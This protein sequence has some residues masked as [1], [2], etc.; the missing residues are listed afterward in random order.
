M[1]FTPAKLFTFVVVVLFGGGLLQVYAHPQPALQNIPLQPKQPVLVSNQPPLPIFG[2]GSDG[3]LVVSNGQTVYTDEIRA[4]LLN[5]VQA[6]EDTICVSITSTF[7]VGDEIL[8]IQIFGDGAGNYEFKHIT[9][10]IDSCWMR[11][12]SGLQQTYTTPN[13]RA[14][15]VRVPNYENV[16]VESGG[17]LTAHEWDGSTGGIVSF[18]C[19]N[20]CEINGLVN[21]SGKGFKGG[22]GN[23]VLINPCRTSNG[24]QGLSFT[25]SAGCTRSANGGGGGAGSGSFGS[26]G[27]GGYGSSG[28]NGGGDGWGAGGEQYGVTDLSKIY[29]GSGGGGGNW[30]TNPYGGGRLSIQGND[31]S[32]QAGGIAYISARNITALNISANGNPGGNSNG[33]FGGHAGGGG[34]GG[35]IKIIGQS[36]VLGS[37]QS[38]GGAGGDGTF[39]DGG[40]GGNGR[41]NIEY[42]DAFSGTTNPPA[43][44][45]SGNCALL[46]LGVVSFDN[47]LSGWSKD[48]L[49]SFRVGTAINPDV[50]VVLLVDRLGKY[51][52]EIVEVSN[53]VVETSQVIPWLEPQ[54]VFELDTAS[55]NNIATFLQWGRETYPAGRTMVTFIGHGTGPSPAL[56]MPGRA[57]VPPL[58]RPYRQR[59]IDVTNGQY[60]STTEL[61]E[62]LNLATNNGAD[63]FDIVFL[64]Q[65][66]G[67][68]IEGLYEIREA[69]ELFIAS[70]NYAWGAFP[71]DAYLASFVTAT[72]NE[73]IA[74]AVLTQ[75]QAALDES[76]PNSIFWTRR[77]EIETIAAQASTL[78]D[79]LRGEIAQNSDL[80]LQASLASQFADTTLTTGDFTLAPPDELIGLGSFA[81]NLQASFPLTSPVGLAAGDLLTS[82]QIVQ[83]QTLSQTG[84]PWSNPNTTW[85]YTDSFTILAPLTRTLTTNEIWRASIY[86]DTENLPAHWIVEPANPVP[87]LINTPLIFT[88]DH[89]W[90]EF[91]SEWYTTELPPSVGL[92]FPTFPQ[93]LVYTNTQILTVTLE[94]GVNQISLHW[95]VPPGLNPAD[96]AIR[97]QQ[98][99]VNEWKLITIS[100]GNKHNYKHWVDFPGTHRFQVIARNNER[101]AIAFSSPVE[102]ITEVEQNILL[103]SESS[104]NTV[105]LEWNAPNNPRVFRYQ[106]KRSSLTNP[107]Y[108]LIESN[109]RENIYFDD[110]VLENGN[111]YCYRVEA[112]SQTDT[113]LETSNTSC[114][115]WQQ[116]ELEIA[117]VRAAAGSTTIVPIRIRNA[118]GLRTAGSEFWLNYDPQI[119]QVTNV[120][121]TAL[122]ESYTTTYQIQSNGVLSQVVISM[123]PAVTPAVPLFD[124]G[125][126]FWLEVE[127]LNVSSGDAPLFWRPFVNTVGGT[128]LWALDPTDNPV[129]VPLELT[130]G[131]ITIANTYM[132]GDVDGNGVINIL[133]VKKTLGIA[134]GRETPPEPDSGL[135]ELQLIAGDLN[136]NGRI[137]A[138]DASL[139]LHFIDQ[140]QWPRPGEAIHSLQVTTPQTMTVQLDNPT[141][142]QG[143]LVTVLFSATNLTDFAGGRVVLTYDPGVIDEVIAIEPLG[144][145][146]DFEMEAYNGEKGVVVAM[147]SQT[148][149]SGNGVVFQLT[150]RLRSTAPTGDNPLQIGSVQLNDPYGRDLVQ[151]ALQHE[152]L[153]T[154]GSIHIYSK[155]FLPTLL[156]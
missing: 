112:F 107:N 108:A 68:S 8:I 81:T 151:S 111:L 7:Q 70:P 131:S 132:L 124:Q 98:P 36:V 137:D 115:R 148:P 102:I 80:I 129:D 100:P 147:A 144:V 14:Q 155:I 139:I 87:V 49:E 45:E 34:S 26:G 12:D 121:P 143:Q 55:P 117:N 94:A 31:F 76:H 104:F 37:V 97:Y 119:L 82:L 19:A 1:L 52:T 27:G 22:Y 122:T 105:R 29:F 10:I 89:S 3:D 78:A 156:R 116:V 69:A 38:L 145:A 88:V 28:G 135:E 103:N 126:L 66:F 42:C 134:I 133:D 13:S 130:L 74:N 86:T 51:N 138:A 65:C 146:Q 56:T 39:F 67:G 61:G 32:G 113:L 109:Y 9:E 15:I 141:G 24:Q 47:D 33:Q 110:S 101:K 6:G 58:P 77:T 2:D 84:S 75:Y 90:D 5:S 140:G 11:L 25:S 20:N 21:V 142:A 60:T 57:I 85:A 72:T 43:V 154:D 71:Y 127:L 41:I 95:E 50:Q 46:I 73:D 93:T 59:P 150:V 128:Q 18:R 35:T 40:N 120:W 136:S 91:I 96:F 123:T 44:V 106:I 63:P 4:Q 54:H 17:I 153:R 79:A 30:G 23:D 62:T 152:I 16:T 48:V 149:I 99:N 83:S 125:A 53:G 92:F 118:A 114:S 64:D